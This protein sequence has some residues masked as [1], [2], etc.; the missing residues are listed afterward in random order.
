MATATRPTVS[1]SIQQD[2]YTEAELVA[3]ITQD[4]YWRFIQEFW[5]TTVKER[6]VWNWHMRYLA[7]RMQACAEE[8]FAGRPKLEDLIINI[9]PGTSKSTIC[10]VLFMPWVWTRMPS[11]RAICGSYTHTLALDL[12]RKARDVV[13]H[14]DYQSAFPH[15]KLRDDQDTKTYFMNTLGG[16]RFS[17]SSG[18]N[19]T[20]MHGH[21]III[22]DPINPEAA[23]SEVE[24]ANINRWVGTTVPSRKVN[25]KTATSFLIMQRLHQNDPTGHLLK[26]AKAKVAHIC[27]PSELSDKVQPV[28]CRKMYKDGLLDPVR[29][30]KEALAEARADL[31]NYGYA[32]QFEQHPIPQDGGM[33]KIG[34]IIIGTPPR[35]FAK[36]YRFWDKAGTH[37]AGCFTVGVKMGVV[38]EEKL[39]FF[40]VLDVRRGQWAPNE[41][42]TIIKQTAM[43][44]G[45]GVLIGL[46]QEP[47]SAGVESTQATMRRLAGFRVRAD[48]PTG[49]KVLRAEA[50][51]VQ[52]DAG[53]VR[54]AQAPWN[55]EY[56]EELEYFPFSTYKDQVDASSGAFNLLAVPTVRAGA[57]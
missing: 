21:F 2:S 36:V 11:A 24:I 41:R 51:A 22:D 26:K 13:R 45:Y 1:P 56:L 27:L 38:Y 49:D 40:W 52:V 10:S 39:P 9:P 4:A 47:G 23:Y 12:S 3:S 54:L 5:H 29:L 34:K 28:A 37:N 43:A 17:A 35:K 50:F 46:E 33:F 42:E 31:G 14:P 25:K 48:K 6:L 19:V 30:D 57:L 44:D 20:G 55:S 7:D 8:V 32:A 18:S 53:A 15:I 16:A